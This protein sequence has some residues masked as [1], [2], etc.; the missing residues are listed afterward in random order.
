MNILK[1]HE[2]EK[3]IGWFI[4]SSVYLNKRGTIS[5]KMSQVCAYDDHIVIV[6]RPKKQIVEV[7]E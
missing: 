7:Y 2:G 6:A 3:Q 4:N 5:V 1:I